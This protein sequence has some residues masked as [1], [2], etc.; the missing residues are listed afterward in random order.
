MRCQIPNNALATQDPSFP[1]GYR[2]ILIKVAFQMLR[3]NQPPM[4]YHNLHSF[5]RCS[6]SPNGSHFNAILLLH[7]HGDHGDLFPGVPGVILL[8]PEVPSSPPRPPRPPPG[9]P[10]PP[11][12]AP[13]CRPTDTRQSPARRADSSTTRMALQR[14]SSAT[15]RPRG[16]H[17]PASAGRS[18]GE[19][20]SGNKKLWV[21]ELR[22]VPCAT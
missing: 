19:T 20:E 6:K 5:S 1:I 22:G 13:S 17:G 18:R 9:H 3:N 21:G 4:E 14:P 11:A 7:V 10:P 12:C 15:E 2:K 8:R 16:R